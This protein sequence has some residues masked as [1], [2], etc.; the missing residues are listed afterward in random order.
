[1]TPAECIHEL[2]GMLAEVGANVA[3]RR[4]SGPPGPARTFTSETVKAVFRAVKG[5]DLAGHTD[6]FDARVILSPTGLATV[7]A[8]DDKVFAEGAEWNIDVVKPFRI[9]TT[10]VRYELLLKGL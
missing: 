8:R 2:D 4:Y 3:I 6:Q 5:E 7:I 9:D 1:M 10:I